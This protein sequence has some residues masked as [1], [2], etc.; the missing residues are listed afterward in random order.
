MMLVVQNAFIGAD[1]MSSFHQA[2]CQARA[3]LG[4][5]RFVPPDYPIHSLDGNR[6]FVRRQAEFLNENHWIRPG[7]FDRPDL[8]HFKLFR[9]GTSSKHHVDHVEEIDGALK[10]FGVASVPGTR[11]PADL[12]VLCD[13][14]EKP[15]RVVAFAESRLPWGVMMTQLDYE[16]DHHEKALQNSGH[17]WFASVPLSTLPEGLRELEVWILDSVKWRAWRLKDRVPV[18]A[19]KGN[20]P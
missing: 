17:Q 10:I 13:G 15:P 2:R 8:E 12:V 3:I 19:V 11:R 18:P 20:A 5:I 7:L 1:L 4:F 16:F 14:R 6:E 9:G